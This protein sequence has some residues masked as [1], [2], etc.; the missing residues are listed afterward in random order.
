MRGWIEPGPRR[1][2]VAQQC[3]LLGLPR[4]TCYARPAGETAQN[5]ILMKRIDEE[6]TKTPFYGSR[7]LAEVLGVNRKRV[8]RH[9]RSS[10]W[11]F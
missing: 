5:L 9:W 7:K 8:Q 3:A 2:S 4:S 11:G 10:C 1:L 6:Y